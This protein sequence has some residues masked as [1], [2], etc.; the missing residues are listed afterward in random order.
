MAI[1]TS[2]AAAGSVTGTTVTPVAGN[3]EG[4]RIT[5]AAATTLVLR[6]INGSGGAVSFVLD[7]PNS[8]TPV[9][10]T[11]FNPDVTISVGATS[12][13]TVVITDLKRFR[14][15]GYVTVTPSSATS[16]TIEAVSL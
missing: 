4:N 16:V 1:T 7:D 9:G 12:S 14:T 13:K 3:T 15:A 11:A 6:L 2:A 5:C 10:A 8:V